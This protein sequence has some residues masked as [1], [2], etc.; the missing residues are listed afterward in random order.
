[1]T[2]RSFLTLLTVAIVAYGSQ[3][4]A[5]GQIERAA[6]ATDTEVQA[7]LSSEDPYSA[8]KALVSH[9]DLLDEVKTSALAEFDAG[10]DTDVAA[11]E[12]GEIPQPAFA[13]NSYHQ[14]LAV[15]VLAE[16][17]RDLL[18]K[19]LVAVEDQSTEVQVKFVEA[20]KLVMK[21]TSGRAAQY[22]TLYAELAELENSEIADL[23]RE[24]SRATSQEAVAA[25][26]RSLREKQAVL[27][28]VKALVPS[29]VEEIVE[30]L[31]EQHAIANRSAG[32][33]Q[34]TF[35]DGPHSTH[36]PKILA[37]LRAHG[38]KAKF[39]WL[40]QNVPSRSGI[41]NNANAQGMTLCNHSY[42]HP[43]LTK[44]GQAG[45]KKEIVDSTTLLTKYYGYRPKWFRCPY[46]ACGKAG[47]AVRKM[48][49][50]EGMTPMFWNVDSLDWSDKSPTSIYKRVKKQMASQGSGIILFHDIH[51]QSVTASEM[52]MRD[53]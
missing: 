2:A 12:R 5:H 52:V 22:E 41:V 8:L 15:K 6:L 47:S 29:V 51:S 35:D 7:L 49:A 30:P 28:E 31:L 53:L 9:I 42:S 4:N 19:S 32:S 43:Q 39:F 34:L 14:L 13:K 45:L 20:F 25:A 1:M 24:L 36:T 38:L 37:N 50:A 40:A 48:I 33:W 44:L 18:M 3:V 46:G 10:L 21:E 23:G 17:D 11:R 16:H 26:P 27:K